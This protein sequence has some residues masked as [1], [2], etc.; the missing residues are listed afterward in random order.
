MDSKTRDDIDVKYKWDL[1]RLYASDEDWEKEYQSI[2]ERAKA[3]RDREDTL[4]SKEVVLDTFRE[5]T[6]IILRFNYLASYATLRQSEDASVA[7][8]RAMEDRISSLASQIAASTAFMVP[9]LL[10][11]PEGTLETYMA[12][13]DFADHD[14]TIRGMIRIKPHSLPKTEEYLVAMAGDV[15]SV[16]S[17]TAELLRSLDLK[18]GSVRNEKGERVPLTDASFVLFLESEDRRVRRTAFRRMMN[19]Y[20]AMGNTFAALY[21]GVVKEGRFSHMVRHYDSARAE[22]MDGDDVPELVYDNLIAAVHEGIGTLG[23]YLELRRKKIGVPHLH[24]YDL[25]Y[26]NEKGFEIHPDIEEAFALFLEAVA[27]LGEDYVRDASR[28]LTER[29]IDVYENKGKRSG[30]YSLGSAYGVTPYVML[31][32]KN[33]YDG[34]STLCH[35]MG[36]AMHSFYS[37]AAQPYPKADYSIFVAEVASTT[38]EILLNEYLRKKY[39]DDRAAQRALIG[40]LLEHFRTTV[41]RQT[42]FAEFEHQAHQLADNG[43]SLTAELL[44]ET[45]LELVKTY[46]GKA[47]T[48]DACV[49]SE[50]MRIPHFYTPFYVY[51]YATS[52]CASIFLARNILSGDPEKVASY[53]RFLT[54]GDSLPPIEELRIAGVDLSTPEPIAQALDYFAELVYEYQTLLNEDE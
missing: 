9:E 40:N 14:R 37:N 26:G 16:P 32:H 17:Q 47:C 22:S 49:A 3:F 8:Y 53:R 7:R 27:P 4:T 45:Y 44:S 50:W 29:W 52:F 25:Y 36:H 12:D 41:F 5:F 33:N 13:P 39:R 23:A 51:K 34:L 28:A 38:N 48:V 20:A 31:N 43:E 18:L 19:G 35:E 15:F 24:M 6:D 30:A 10:A 1:T 42:M 46:Y 2:S 21:G 54:L 11:L